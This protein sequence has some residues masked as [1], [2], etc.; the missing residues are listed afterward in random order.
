[1]LDRSLAVEETCEAVR[2]SF[3]R[4]KTF[5]EVFSP[6]LI[7]QFS[8]DHFH[9]FSY[10]LMPSFCVGA[11]T[12]A[13]GDWSIRAQPLPVATDSALA[14]LEAVREAEIDAALSYDMVVDHGFVQMWDLLFGR[15][16]SY[17][18]VPSP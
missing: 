5:I 18:L 17:P 16:H 1:M 15:S 7:V 10:A 2:G 14:L 4:M 12:R 8:P 9:G 6:E 11:E 13:Y 3:E